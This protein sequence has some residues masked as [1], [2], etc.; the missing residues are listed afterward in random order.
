MPMII[1]RYL[2]QI[3]SEHQQNEQQPQGQQNEQQPQ[4]QQQIEN[5][6]LMEYKQGKCYIAYAIIVSVCYS[7]FAWFLKM[8]GPEYGMCG[9][10]GGTNLLNNLYITIL[11]R[12]VIFPIIYWYCKARVFIQSEGGGDG[13]ALVDK[14]LMKIIPI[15][16]S[17]MMLM[18][19]IREG[20]SMVY[21]CPDV[22]G[23]IIALVLRQIIG[24]VDCILYGFI[25]FRYA[26][27]RSK[28]GIVEIQENLLQ[29]NRDA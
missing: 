8:V 25:L 18:V 19:I 1:A 13:L 24:A 22:V 9:F 20:L 23:V 11:P 5:E 26:S 14:K 27:R 4:S 28:N 21:D 10:R 3:Y 7:I 17:A 16:S 29:R 12:L 6:R 2:Y 15:V